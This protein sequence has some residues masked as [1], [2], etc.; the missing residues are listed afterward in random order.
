MA[1]N[2]LDIGS[3]EFPSALMHVSKRFNFSQFS[4]KLPLNS[5]CGSGSVSTIFKDNSSLH[6]MTIPGTIWPAN[7]A[8]IS[9]NPGANYKRLLQ[10]GG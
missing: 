9:E 10:N 2:M 6:S 1:V 7:F 5:C 3:D 8:G 4:T